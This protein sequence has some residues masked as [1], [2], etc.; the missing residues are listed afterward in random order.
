MIFELFFIFLLIG[1][2]YLLIKNIEWKIRFETKVRK[3]IEKLERKIRED[4][5]KRSSRI[6]SGKIVEQIL[7]VSKEF[8][9][10]PHDV[11]WLGEPVDF[12]IFDGYSEKSINNVIFCEVKT[13]SSKLSKVQDSLKRA[14]KNKKVKWMEVRI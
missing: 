12:I 7:P 6:L 10:N 14:I 4:A 3:K 8:P 5:I 13:G 11:R 2:F 1:F 9:F